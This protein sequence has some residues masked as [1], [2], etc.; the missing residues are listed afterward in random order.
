MLSEII[1]AY[2][3][4]RREGN[5]NEMQR[6]E[7]QLSRLGMDRYSLMAIVDELDKKE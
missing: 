6:L 1:D 2:R 4:A 5:K 3:M 7:K